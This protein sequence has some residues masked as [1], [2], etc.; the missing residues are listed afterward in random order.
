MAARMPA[1]PAP[2]IKTSCFASTMEEAIEWPGFQAAAP[3]GEGPPRRAAL[4]SSRPLLGAGP[5]LPR[6]PGGRA[7]VVGALVVEREPV[8]VQRSGR[9]AGGVEL[10][11]QRVARGDVLE[12]RIARAPK[13]SVVLEREAEIGLDRRR[14]AERETQI[15]DPDVA[16]IDV[17]GRLDVRD[18]VA[19][20][21][22]ADALALVREPAIVAGLRG[23]PGSRRG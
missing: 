5:R 20:D 12:L 3:A 8:E 10:A 9:I 2:T 23:R 22:E 6:V 11:G 1:Q 15:R 18:P 7:V 21:V 4:P 13:R 16:A 17:G 19:V 14:V